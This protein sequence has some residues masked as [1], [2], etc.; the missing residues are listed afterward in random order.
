MRERPIG[1]SILA[2]VQALVG[3][4][5][6]IYCGAALFLVISSWLPGFPAGDFSPVFWLEV[7]LPE[8]AGLA[9]IA[10]AVGI[11]RRRPWAWRM[12]ALAQ[13]PILTLGA[14]RFA[15]GLQDEGVVMVGVSGVSLVYLIFS[16]VR[17]RFDRSP[18]S[19]WSPYRP[20][21]PATARRLADILAIAACME[22]GALAAAPLAILVAGF[23]FMDNPSAAPEFVLA[24]IPAFWL[25]FL[26]VQQL[27]FW[28]GIESDRP[29]VWWIGQSIAAA[30]ALGIVL[31]WVGLVFVA[32]AVGCELVLQQD[33]VK[34]A[35]GADD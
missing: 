28:R 17:A 4:V 31:G 12:A 11:W 6:L 3:S 13:T 7:L 1:L 23:L 27:R 22:V 26:A 18:E 30:L 33:E 21:I 10:V 29:Q 35:L 19:D 16:D 9:L 32:A 15:V 14:Y 2:V 25:A 20:Q 5:L 8:A 34:V 24:L